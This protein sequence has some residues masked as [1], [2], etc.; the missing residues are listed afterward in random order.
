MSSAQLKEVYTTRKSTFAANLEHTVARINLISALRLIAAIAFIIALYFTFS[1]STLAF[2]CA[3]LLGCFLILVKIHAKL[4]FAKEHLENLVNIN[5]RELKALDYDFEE[6]YGGDEFID[7]RHAYAHDLDLFGKGSLFQYLNRA[8]TIHGR[9]ALASGLCHPLAD[10]IALRQRQEAVMEISTLI[11]FRQ[12]LQAAGMEIPE[13]SADYGQLMQWARQEPFFKHKKLI[14][15]LLILI[16]AITLGALAATFFFPIAKIVLFAGILSQWALT[17][18][19][20]KNI[21]I[22]HDYISRKKNILEKYAHFLFYLENQHFKSSSLGDIASR[23]NEACRNIRK[24]ASLV[25]ALD[26]RTNSLAA[27]F[28]NSFLLYDL[29]CVYR[30]EVWREA[31]AEKLKLWIDAITEIEVLNS[32]GTFHYNNPSFCLPDFSDGLTITATSLGHPLISA[33]ER[34]ANDL[35]FGPDPSV[36]IITGANMAGK[37]T[38]LR[39]LGVNIVL[40]LNGAPVCASQFLCPLV[41][42]RTGMRT[43][44]S[45]RDHQSYFYAELYRLKGIMDE[46]RSN[47]PLLVL[48]DEIL[49]GTNSNDK[50]AGSI[51]L[52]KQFLPHRCLAIIATHDLALGDLEKAYPEKVRNFCF[53]ANIEN[54]QLSFDYKLKTGIAQ[55]MNASFLMKKMGIIA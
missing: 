38:F 50:Q 31:N 16:P 51:A 12:H 2:L 8:N 13:Q 28:V 27:V 21:N 1:N 20:L 5:E 19:L 42:L 3:G 41:E 22:Y 6:R 36:L 4:F 49:K 35:T 30:L 18:M 26:A 53:E 24:L 47:R 52:V 9:R 11:D 54:D 40:A 32:I 44:D 46:L 17:G 43:A 7:T 55:K 37:S 39:T 23:A 48:L 29:Q 14:S 34:V 10:K 45:L 33:S 25:G 15:I